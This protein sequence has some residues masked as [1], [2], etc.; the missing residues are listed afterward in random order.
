MR[1]LVVASGNSGKIR[2]MSHY[3]EPY[4]VKVI[5]QAVLGVSE[6]EEPALTFVENALIKAR[7]ASTH[8]GRPAL[9]DDSGLCVEALAGEPGV[10]SARFAGEPK[11]DGA[12]NQKLLFA[13]QGCT[14]RK[15]HYYCVMVYVRHARDPEPVIAEGRWYGEIAMHLKG[16]KGFGYDPLFYLPDYGLTA[17]QI[18]LDQKNRISHRAKA[19]ANL[20]QFFQ[21]E[22]KDR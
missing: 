2:E 11:S 19:M 14:N 4:G 1:E 5:P 6:P 3:L 10:Q 20:I 13:L 21:N 9:A 22:W 17:A 8:T 18:D 15:A 7:H 12:N 16:D